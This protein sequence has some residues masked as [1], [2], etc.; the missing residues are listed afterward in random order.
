MSKKGIF[1]GLGAVVLAG[2][3]GYFGWSYSH[4]GGS[5]DV[6]SMAKSGASESQLLDAI[7]HSSGGYKLT[8]DDVI[9][10]HKANV[11]DKVIIAMLQKSGSA[12]QMAKK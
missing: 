3:A 5:S 1:L 10:L 11:S 4:R 6:L 8:S 2:V 12:T 7:D 9:A